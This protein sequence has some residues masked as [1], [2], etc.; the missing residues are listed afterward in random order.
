VILLFPCEPFS[1]GRIDP[2]FVAEYEA[3]KL[4][5]FQCFSYSHEDLEAGDIDSCLA[6]LPPRSA[7]PLILV[8]GWMVPGEAYRQ[9]HAGLVAKGYL[10]L[11]APEAYDEAH[12]LPLA[13]RI[14]EPYTARSAWIE[15]DDE[16][17]AW[18]LYQ[19]FNACDAIIK[20]WVKSAKAHWKEAC[21]IPVGTG[22]ER[23][24][25]IFRTF[26]K[27]RS[28]L[29]NRGVVL[30]EFMPLARRGGNIGDLPIVE[31]T[32]LFFWQS[33]CITPVHPPALAGD[34]S[35]WT[36]IARRFLSPFVTIDVARLEDGSWKI[37]ETGDGQVSGL[38]LGF[39]QERF[40]ATLR[41]RS[42]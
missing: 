27:E 18:T 30:R 31:E 6:A 24:G 7:D 22:R 9:L 42:L 3:A 37:V 38:P 16:D 19:G 26:R 1:P 15:G 20:D 4:V 41:N 10:P 21:F 8:R 35:L 2:D 40:Y 34:M 14:T 33:E 11:T 25:E 17:S 13:Y 36:S 5:G 32:R 12:Y 29:F 23:F 39:D 28:K